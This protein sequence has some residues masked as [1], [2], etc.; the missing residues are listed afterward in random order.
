MGGVILGWPDQ[1]RDEHWVRVLNFL[2]EYRDL[3]QE[4]DLRV[5][6]HTEGA[7]MARTLGAEAC[8][9]PAAN[10]SMGT[11]VLTPQGTEFL[12]TVMS[13]QSTWKGGNTCGYL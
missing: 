10:K 9:G 8:P 1:L 7:G 2:E 5:R 6:G 12:S 13:L 3:K 4:K 11:P